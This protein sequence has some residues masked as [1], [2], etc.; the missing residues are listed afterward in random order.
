MN[1][2]VRFSNTLDKTKLTKR[3]EL[4]FLPY[5]SSFIVPTAT[6]GQLGLCV[7]VN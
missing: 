3:S 1:K 2:T 6:G 4:G 7:E 5:N